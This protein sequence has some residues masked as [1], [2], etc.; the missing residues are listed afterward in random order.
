MTDEIEA[1][2]EHTCGGGEPRKFSMWFL[3]AML[4]NLVANLCRA[5]AAVPA[6]FANF[7]DEAQEAFGAHGLYK[8][9][10]SVDVDV[11]DSFREQLKT[12]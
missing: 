1:P 3:P 9:Q 7:W 11:V 8:Q 10:K 2:E 6:S 5:L 4:S 12:L